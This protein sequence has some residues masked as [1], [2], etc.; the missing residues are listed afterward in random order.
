MAYITIQELKDYIRTLTSI[1]AET[2][3]AGEDAM[4]QTLVDEAQA[5]IEQV[6]KRK[7]EASTQTRYYLSNNLR[8]QERAELQYTVSDVTGAPVLLLDEDLISITTI[9]NG[10]QNLTVVPSTDYWLLPFNL[11]PKYGLQLKPTASIGA[12]ES[13]NG[14]RISILGSWGFSSTANNDIK[15]LTKRIAYFFYIKRNQADE[16]VI[17]SGGM[18][19]SNSEFPAD[20]KNSLALYTRKTWMGAN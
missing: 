8:Y 18:T 10:D 17:F 3:T 2:F 6:T 4:W 20:I 7:F 13:S 14:N 12:W 19:V 11:T 1:S 5:E 15:R 9:T 16:K